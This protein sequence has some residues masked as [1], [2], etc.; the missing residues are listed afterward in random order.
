MQRLKTDFERLIAEL[1]A[2]ARD[3]R[4]LVAENKRALGR[5]EPRSRAFD[6]VR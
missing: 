2:D 5:I 6:F 4:V 1:E 3:C